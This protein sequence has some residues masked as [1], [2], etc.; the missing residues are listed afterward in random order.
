MG[1]CGGYP[2]PCSIVTRQLYLRNRRRIAE[3]APVGRGRRCAVFDLVCGPRQG[4][5]LRRRCDEPG[6]LAE[7]FGGVLSVSFITDPWSCSPAV[8]SFGQA[9]CTAVARVALSEVE[10]DVV[11]GSSW[12]CAVAAELII[13]RSWSGPTL[14]LAPAISKVQVRT[15]PTCVSV[16][17]SVL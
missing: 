2:S 11:V 8:V 16:S 14:L 9:R 6:T 15:P 17:P 5:R 13:E 1:G 10:P 12:G 7:S 3:P 4:L